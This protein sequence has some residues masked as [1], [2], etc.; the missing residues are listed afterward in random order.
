MVSEHFVKGKLQSCQHLYG[1]IFYAGLN[2][3][4][5]IYKFVLYF[6]SSL[7]Q[8]R[9]AERFDWRRNEYLSSEFSLQITWGKATVTSAR[10][11]I[12][13]YEEICK[14]MYHDAESLW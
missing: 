5:Q 11:Y 10:S 9:N 3:W 12:C 8:R 2:L 1:I 6:R 13:T 7:W 14:Y 4:V